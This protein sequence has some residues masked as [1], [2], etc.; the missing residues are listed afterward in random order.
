M[1]QR[2]AQVA[3]LS[4]SSPCASASGRAAPWRASALR[5][6]FSTRAAV[7]GGIAAHLQGEEL[8]DRAPVAAAHPR[9][10]AASAAPAR[11]RSGQP[12]AARKRGVVL[13]QHQALDA[14]GHG[15][16]EIERELAA[17]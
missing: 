12:G 7:R 2:R 16:G 3:V 13:D 4:R 15:G 9:R 1:R 14:R 11:C 5:S 6:V 17:E 8:I 10:R